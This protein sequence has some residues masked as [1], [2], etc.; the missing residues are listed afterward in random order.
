MNPDPIIP[1]HEAFF[2]AGLQLYTEICKLLDTL[3]PNTTMLVMV[4]LVGWIGIS[5]FYNNNG[6]KPQ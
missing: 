1:I 4:F 3:H 6:G 2:L 5:A